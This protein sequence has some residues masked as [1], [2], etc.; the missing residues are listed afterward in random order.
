M[1]DAT[2]NHRPI[3][4]LRAIVARRYG[5]DQVRGRAGGWVKNRPTAGSTWPPGFRLRDGSEVV[6]QTAPPPEVR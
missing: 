6:L 3:E 4:T 2:K 1:E 5:P